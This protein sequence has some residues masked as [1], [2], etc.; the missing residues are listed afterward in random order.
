MLRFEPGCEGEMR[1][2]VSKI[3]EF[4]FLVI[5]AATAA[6]GIATSILAEEKFMGTFTAA[7]TRA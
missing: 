7:R 4:F 6:P 2:E 1:S 5:I 3:V